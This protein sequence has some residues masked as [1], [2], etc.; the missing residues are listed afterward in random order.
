M[1][2][3]GRMRVRMEGRMRD[4][5]AVAG[6]MGEDE[7]WRNR[8]KDRGIDGKMGEM[9][10]DEEKTEQNIQTEGWMD[11]RKDEQVEGWMLKG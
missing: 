2:A 11:T 8:R 6:R 9:H 3:D 4:D 1:G 5:G 10:Q 7:G